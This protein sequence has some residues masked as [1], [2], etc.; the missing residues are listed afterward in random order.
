MPSFVFLVYHKP[1][2]D[3]IGMI[4]V[5]YWEGKEF[6]AKGVVQREGPGFKFP[7]VLYDQVWPDN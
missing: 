2:E 3:G 5:T 1:S 7:E 4:L 6:E